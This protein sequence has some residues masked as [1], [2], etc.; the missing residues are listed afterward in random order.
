VQQVEATG[1]Q[2]SVEFQREVPAGE[3][4]EL[5]LELP[6]GGIA[7]VVLGPDGKPV[8]GARVSLAVDG[9][10]QNGS[11][12]GGNYAEVSAGPDGR[13][14][15]R[16]LRPGNYSVA[17]GG[18]LFG[19]LFGDAGGQ[20]FGRQV[21]RG[22]VVGEGQWLRGVD[23]RLRTPGR[24]EGRVVGASG[25]AVTGA[26]I[27]L[28]DEDGNTIDRIS[29]VATDATGRFEY[30]GLEEGLYQVSARTA[31]LVSPEPQGVRV[32]AGEASAV[33]LTLDQ[34][35][36]LVVGLSDGDGNSVRCSLVVTDPNGQQ[37]NGLWSMTD[38]MSVFSGGG[39]SSD[40]Q[41]VGP[42][43]PGKYRLEA[44]SEDGRSAKKSVTLEGQGERRIRLRL[45]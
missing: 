36:V 45:D 7:G 38:L 12:T 19:G 43:A 25:E 29:M 33:T 37:V 3:E 26:A 4:H 27:F 1:Q 31:A 35:T 15:L 30:T 2:Q 40:E 11:V 23:F 20:T 41:R 24:I 42:L 17:A 16:W 21:R 14:E 10:I 22:L 18:A 34:G 13:Y 28:R 9:P 5:L 32:T 6:V 8:A 44:T 39:I